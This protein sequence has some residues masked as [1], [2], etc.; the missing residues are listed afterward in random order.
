MTITFLLHGYLLDAKLVNKPPRQFG[1]A[2]T[3][4]TGHGDCQLS[5]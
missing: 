4:P 3:T 1:L 2:G 5:L